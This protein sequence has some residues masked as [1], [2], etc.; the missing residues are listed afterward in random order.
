MISDNK[1]IPARK[2]F[3]KETITFP[4]ARNTVEQ[5]QLINCHVVTGK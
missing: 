2:V 5:K 1:T 4:G 3:F